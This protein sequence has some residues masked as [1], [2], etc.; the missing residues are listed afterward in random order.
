MC[1]NDQGG[2]RMDVTDGV[3]ATLRAQANHP[4]VV[5]D[6]AGFCTEESSK[7]RSIGY[8]EERSPTLRAGVVPATVTNK[9]GIN[10]T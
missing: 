6:S 3:T 4:P 9:G 10:E 5:I 2:S 8:E 7:T 1:L